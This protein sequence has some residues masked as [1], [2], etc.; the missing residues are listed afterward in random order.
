MTCKSALTGMADARVVDLD[1]DLMG[2]WRSDLD[3]L[4][5]QLLASLPCNGCLAVDGLSC[6]PAR[7]RQQLCLPRLDIAG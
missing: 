6:E 2:L 1:A 7:R 4:D 3:V 5:A